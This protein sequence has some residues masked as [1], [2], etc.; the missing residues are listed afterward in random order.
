MPHTPVF[1]SVETTDTAH[2]LDLC[3]KIVDAGCGIKLGM[4]YFNACGPDGIKRIVDAFPQ[5]PVFL[6]LKHHDIPQTVA[7]AIKAALP[8]GVAYMN[9]HAAGGYDMMKAAREALGDSKT[10]LLAVT[11]LTSIDEENLAR[12]GQKGPVM[13]QVVRLASLTQEAGLHGIV[14]SPL[15][16]AA[17]RAA[18]GPDFVLMVPGIRPADHLAGSDDQRRIMTPAAAMREGA[19]HLVIGRPITGAPDPATAARDIV[20]SLAA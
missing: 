19:T 7:K 8:L 15:E 9:V 20:A 18:C 14:C 1:C 4:E 2:A 10:K 3:R 6:D 12:I 16:I 11:V 5:I 13:E 17:V